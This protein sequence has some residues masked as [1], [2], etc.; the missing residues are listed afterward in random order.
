[1][2]YTVTYTDSITG[3]ED[4]QWFDFDGTYAHSSHL[5]EIMCALD[6]QGL[7]LVSIAVTKDVTVEAI[8]DLLHTSPWSNG[9]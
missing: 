5:T 9:F 3:T 2:R 8:M 4:S 7:D 6:V 1:M